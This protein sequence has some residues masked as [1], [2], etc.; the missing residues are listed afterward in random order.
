[1][2]LD[3]QQFP[4]LCRP[5]RRCAARLR[6]RHECLAQIDVVMEDFDDVFKLAFD[7]IQNVLQAQL[8]GFSG[9]RHYFLDGFAIGTLG[10]TIAT[11][12]IRFKV[13]AADALVSRCEREAVPLWMLQPDAAGRTGTCC[14]MDANRRQKNTT[15]RG[16][17]EKNTHNKK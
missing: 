7:T 4:S 9:E 13:E 10:D 3:Q 15:R 5:P 8:A 14:T 6:A 11:V 2:H 1:M 12:R 17:P 16:S